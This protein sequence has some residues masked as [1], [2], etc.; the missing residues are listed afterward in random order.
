MAQ[1]R[2][3]PTPQ[4]RQQIFERDKDESG[5]T[6][7]YVCEEYIIDGES[8]DVDHIVALADGGPNKDLSNF[9]A[10]H[11]GCNLRKGVKSLLVARNEYR[12]LKK[13]DEDFAKLLPPYKHPE[14]VVDEKQM[15]VRFNGQ[16][17]PLYRCPNTRTLY[18]YHLIPI[19]HIRKDAA[20]Q[21][22]PLY[23]DKILGLGRHLQQ[24]F[25]LS[26]AVCR[27]ENGELLLF[28]GQHK[29]AAQILWNGT[30]AIECK[31]II[32]QRTIVDRVIEHAHGDLRQMQFKTHELGKKLRAQFEAHINVWRANHPGQE[33]SESAILKDQLGHSKAQQRKDI[34]RLI[35]ES[36]KEQSTIGQYISGGRDRRFPMTANMF[37]VVL[38]SFVHA[39]PLDVPIESEQD[40]RKEELENLT[41]LMGLIQQETLDGH[42]PPDGN[43]KTAEQERAKNLWREA[44]MEAWLYLLCEGLRFLLLK[45]ADKPVCYGNEW[46]DEE[47]SRV[48]AAAR[49]LFR[50]PAWD[51]PVVK[52][53]FVTRV[54]KQ[55]LDRLAI[56]GL[57]PATVY[58]GGVRTS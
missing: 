44:P 27:L 13:F 3:T 12:V 30:E 21:P 56:Q 9:A 20:V 28:D 46:A 19:K 29:A 18:F 57:I 2:Y 40:Y 24:H 26:P 49:T 36:V 8:W 58:E 48:A 32:A 37:E 35:A 41:F 23:K 33:P 15:L 38:A 39:D 34:L 55:L 52:E 47:K 17:L 50:H 22:R 6:K 14:I 51:N 4:E 43:P 45:P 16:D 11:H 42:W 10:A 31:V 5:K 7:C 54:K 1:E 53:M 25:Q